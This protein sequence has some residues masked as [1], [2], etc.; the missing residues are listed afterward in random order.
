M[1]VLSK[2]FKSKTLIISSSILGIGLA[3]RLI[4]KLFI[5]IKRENSP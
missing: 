3:I 2:I 1:T 4:K 5:L